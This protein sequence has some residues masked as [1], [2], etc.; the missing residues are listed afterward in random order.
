MEGDFTGERRTDYVA[1]RGERAP[2]RKPQDNLKP[3]GEFDSVTTTE[4]VFTGKPGE[5]PIPV[6]R[7][8]YTKVEGDFTDETTSRTEY[9]DH[10]TVKRAE[11]FRRADNLTIGEGDF[12]VKKF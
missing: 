11:I 10:R 6:R 3:E 1:T 9:I 8:T 12:T 2:V 5:R 4:L 7:N